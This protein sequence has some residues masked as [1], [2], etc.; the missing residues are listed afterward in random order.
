MQ[1]CRRRVGIVT[2]H[3]YHNYGNRLQNYALQ[4]IINSLGYKSITLIIS[5]ETNFYKLYSARFRRLF[6]TSFDSILEKYLARKEKKKFYKNN[7]DLIENR[8]LVFKKF[9][10]EYLS[11]KH[12]RI[13]LNSNIQFYDSYEYFITGS[14]QV[15]NPIYINNMHRYFLDFAEKKKRIAYAPS[16]GC[17]KIPKTYEEKYRNW[18]KSMSKVSVREEDGAKIIKELTGINAPVLVDPTLLLS[19]EQW[20]SVANKA[21]NR[22]EDAYILT[23]FLGETNGNIESYIKNLARE[24][25]MKIIRLGDIHDRETYVTGP[26]EFIDY[27]NSASMF[28]TDSFH[29]VVFSI[30]LE[31]PF[32]VYERKTKVATMYSRI[33]TLLDKFDLTHREYKNFSGD[34][35]SVDYSHVPNIL[36]KERNKAMEYLIDA[37]D[38]R[39]EE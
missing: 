35:F 3:G 9:S 28:F 5:E 33:E 30:L 34:V 4:T 12:V 21:S 27:V 6:N 37:L 19:K 15:W 39:D 29:G 31:T 20:L 22:P 32:L 36:E 17:P 10:E 7:M 11:E 24:K 18:L 8:T 2:L 26:R 16:F 13:S 1:C 25:N 38:I 23:Y 14:D